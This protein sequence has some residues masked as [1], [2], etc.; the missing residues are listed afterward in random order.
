MQHE[1]QR[2]D[3]K[4][5]SEI[6]RDVLYEILT[7]RQA[8]FVVEQEC[9]YLDTDGQDPFA[10]H[11]LG[12]S[13]DNTLLCYSRVFLPQSKEPKATIGRVIVHPKARGKGLGFELMRQSEALAI[14]HSPH[15]IPHF[16]FLHKPIFNTSTVNWA[17]SSQVLVMMKME[18][19]TCQ[20][21]K[22]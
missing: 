5:W 8:I 12:Y 22:N 3:W 2:W 1:I 4:N 16:R 13:D 18:Y 17:I 11:V 14:Q 10:A 20:C 19:H 21:K 15:Q 6:S 7:L 9:P